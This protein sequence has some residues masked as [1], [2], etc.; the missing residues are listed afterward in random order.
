MAG[1]W[2]LMVEFCAGTSGLEH[3][4]SWVGSYDCIDMN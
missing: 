1:A 4:Q 2:D 3:L